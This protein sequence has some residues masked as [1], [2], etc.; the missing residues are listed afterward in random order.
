LRRS[1]AQG[2]DFNIMLMSSGHYPTLLVGGR[3]ANPNRFYTLATSDDP[4]QELHRSDDG[5]LNWTLAS[6]FA[7]K[8]N[9]QGLEYDPATPDRVYVAPGSGGVKRS[10]D[11][12]QTWT[13]LGL[14]DQRVN[15]LALGVDGG[16]L[17]A[18]TDTGVFR[19]P[20]R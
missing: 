14:A 6:T 20:L 17:Y 7:T 19:L 8:A 18:A 1:P 10:D 15:G 12:G 11:G 13:D 4:T 3:G 2:V 16:N 5:G 9:G